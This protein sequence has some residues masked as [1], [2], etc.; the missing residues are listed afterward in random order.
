MHPI[1]VQQMASHQIDTFNR[2]AAGHRRLAFV[3]GAPAR[4]VLLRERFNRTTGRLRLILQG[5]AA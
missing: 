4:P 3:A 5:S 2:E 1:L